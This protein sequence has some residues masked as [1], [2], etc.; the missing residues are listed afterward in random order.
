[1]IQ[2]VLSGLKLAVLLAVLS[3]LNAAP[4]SSQIL[5]LSSDAGIDALKPNTELGEKDRLKVPAGKTVRIMLPSGATS[6]IQGPAD[7]P[8]RELTGGQVRLESLWQRVK[9]YLAGRDS[10]KAAGSRGLPLAERGPLAVSALLSWTVVPI[11]ANSNGAI[12]VLNGTPLSFAR[13]SVA[14]PAGAAEKEP[15]MKLALGEKLAEDA[16]VVTWKSTDEKAPW[17]QKIRVFDGGRYY[18]VP[19]FTVPSKFDLKMIE[20]ASVE[21]SQILVVLNENKCYEQINAWVNSAGRRP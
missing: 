18:A 8:V 21:G 9:G 1:L 11:P 3:G 4:A 7:R 5:I 15:S 6:V 13:L 16:A 17:P 19:N 14:P 12:C 2:Q 20:R 10:A